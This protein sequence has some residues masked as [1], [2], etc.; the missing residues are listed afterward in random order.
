MIRPPR[1]ADLPAVFA[2]ERDVFGAHVYP[3]FFFRQAFDL[4]GDTFFVA[5]GEGGV[6]DGYVIG[7]PCHEPGVMW[8]LSLAVRG[9][10]RGRG[11]GKALMREVLAAMR[12]KGASSVKLTVHPDNGAVSLYR[13]LGFEVVGEER[14]YFGENDPRLVMV[15]GLAGQAPRSSPA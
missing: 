13:S 2:V 4:W 14:H 12:G 6:L 11:I 8:I 3:D 10:S 1:K 5:E 15:L 7:T 9:A